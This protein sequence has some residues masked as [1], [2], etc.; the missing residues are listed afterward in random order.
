VN[1]RIIGAEKV[2]THDGIIIKGYANPIII[3]NT[4]RNEVEHCRASTLSR[5][6]NGYWVLHDGQV[7]RVDRKDR[8]YG[9]S[10]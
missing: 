4:S 10:Y 2:T 3:D 8:G 7:L 1:D 9:K 6:V 5:L